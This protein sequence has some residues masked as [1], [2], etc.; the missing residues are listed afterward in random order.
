MAA[1]APLQTDEVTAR[2]QSIFEAQRQAIYCRTDKMFAALMAVQWA[3]AVLAACCLSP[4]TWAGTESAVHPH[5]FAAVFL[6]GLLSLFPIC[7]AL[8]RPG[9]MITR[10]V[11][12]VSQLLMSALLIHVSGGRIAT[13]FHIFGSLAF[14]AFYRDWRVLLSATIVTATDHFVR[15]MFWPQSVYGLASAAPWLTVEH[16]GWVGFTDTFLLISCRQSLREMFQISL[17]QA[18]LE[19][20]DTILMQSHETLETRVAQRTEALAQM[21]RRYALLLESAGE[22]IYGLDAQGVTQFVNAAAAKM[23]GYEVSELIGRPMHALLHH[24]HAD[25]RAYPSQDCPIY[26]CLHNGQVRRTDSEVFWRKDGTAFDVEYIATPVSENGE[27][28]G[29][30]VTFQDVTERRRTEE[31]LRESETRYRGLVE[32]SPAAVFVFSEGRL[33]YVNAAM[34]AMMRAKCAEELIGRDNFDFVHP[35]SLA[36]VRERAAHSR[37]GGTNP[38]VQLKYVRLDGGVIDV[39][40]VSSA[41]IYEGK[42]AGQVLVRDI[43]ESK[44]A[45]VALL[46]SET[47]Y[48][49]LVEQSPEAIFVHSGGR[50]VYVNAAM[51]A[52]LAAGSAEVLTGRSLYDFIH[53][54]SLALVRRRVA[55]SLT[56]AVNPLV[57]LRFLRLDGSPVDVEGVSGGVLYAGEPAGQ[58][59]L[60]D[61]TERKRA[62]ESILA[63]HAE[64]LHA[65]D[66]TIEGWSRALDLRDHETEGH[67]RRVTEMTLRLARAVGLPEAELVHIRRGALLHDIGKMGVPDSVLLKPGPLD[68]SEWA[69]MRRHPALAKEMLDPAE[70]L[71]PALTIPYCHHEKWDGSG[72]PQGLCGNQIPLAARLF[73]LVDVWDALSSDRPYRASWAPARV[74]DHLRG[75]AGTHF[76]PGLVPVFLGLLNENASEK[77]SQDKDSQDEDSQIVPERHK[78]AA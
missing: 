36:L 64:L 31:A 52:L 35:D 19:V 25:G 7:L 37:G 12:A 38:L 9:Q 69:I 63:L 5:V 30:V 42:P 8:L 72:Y 4:R 50:F 70:F 11:I 17:R 53:P 46:E 22:G 3:G 77:D 44:R 1:L 57:Q 32:H 61:I 71:R 20:A 28:L 21:Q 6:G 10:Q 26:H 23:L 16:A 15:G 33:V 68:D 24:T 40:A 27:R 39:E 56:G 48:R 58:V 65:Y 51:A 43:S 47:R 73:A 13:H 60:R 78:L 2:A 74:Q 29:A 54:D 67:S 75:L 76:D 55:H 66:A 62:E 59:V 14:L 49:S 18:Q 45:E 34:V 41:I